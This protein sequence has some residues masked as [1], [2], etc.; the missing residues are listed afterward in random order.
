MPHV[1]LG[2]IHLF[3]GQ[4]EEKLKENEEGYRLEPQDT[5]NAHNLMEA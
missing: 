3:L 5:V 1:E 2:N 4:L